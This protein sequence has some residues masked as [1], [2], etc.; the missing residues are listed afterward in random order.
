MD[1]EIWE[2][3]VGEKACIECGMPLWKLKTPIKTRF[4][5]KVIMFEET[6]EF[7]QVIWKAKD[8]HFTTKSSKSSNVDHC[9]N[10]QIMP[11]LYGHGLSYESVSWSLAIVWCFNYCHYPNYQVT[12]LTCWNETSFKWDKGFKSL[13]L[14]THLL[15]KKDVR[16]CE[17]FQ[18][19]P[20]IYE[21]F[22]VDH[23]YNMFTI[24]L[25]SW[26][27]SLW[28]VKILVGHGDANGLTFKYVESCDPLF[29][30]CF[31]TLNPTIEACTSSHGDELEHEGNILGLEHLLRS[32]LKHLSLEIYLCLW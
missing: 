6:L 32:L 26:F 17:I 27:K 22:D 24:M 1:K 15:P 7:K 31:E 25:D 3:E 11:E 16:S 5:S 13:W 19:F 20:P 28:V 4:A 21:L 30:T 12:S 2:N 29:M 10:S 18:T 9:R 23:V 8:Y 14:Q